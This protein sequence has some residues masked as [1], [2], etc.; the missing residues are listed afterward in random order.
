MI[1]TKQRISAAIIVAISVW[2]FVH[3]ALAARFDTDPWRFFGF[4]MYA[5]PASYQWVHVY[6]IENGEEKL[7]LA[8][9]MPAAMRQEHNRF[10][11][12]R[13]VLGSL[14]APHRLA[15]IALEELPHIEGVKIYCVRDRVSPSTSR[16]EIDP[17]VVYTY[18]R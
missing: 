9:R 8:A 15:E 7:M 16:I 18:E 4:A 5:V 14:V 13:A 1:R 6:K 12:D 3:I 17:A 2:A 11:R 10:K